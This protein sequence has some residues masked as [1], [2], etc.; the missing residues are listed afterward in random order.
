MV[1]DGA[2]VTVWLGCLQLQCVAKV[3]CDVLAHVLLCWGG[4]SAREVSLSAQEPLG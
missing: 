3:Q 4:C 2:S 1:H